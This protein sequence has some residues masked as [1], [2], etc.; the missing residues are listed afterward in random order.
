[1]TLWTAAGL[2][3]LA[4]LVGIGLSV[5]KADGVSSSR[6]TTASQSA[7]AQSAKP[8]AKKKGDQKET[9]VA[10]V[11]LTEIKSGE[12]STY[13]QNTSTL[14]ARN[15]AVLV[16]RRQGQ[17]TAILAEE[18]AW[19]ERGAVLARLDD[20]EAKLAVEKSQLAAEVAKREID[21]AKQ[22]NDQGY[23]SAKE[24]DDLEVKLRNATVELEQARYELSQRVITAPFAGRIVDRMVQLGETV[25][26][27]RD[28]FRIADFQPVLARVYFP[29]RELARVKVGQEATLAL[30]SQPGRTISGRVALVNPVVDRTNGT[31]EVTIEVPNRDGALRPGAVARVRIK[32]GHFAEAILM[33]RRGVL[34]E[35]GEDYVFV[36]RA[37]TVARVPITV[38]TIDG[39][40]MQIL[41]GLRPGD[42]VVTVGQ[43]GLKP[44]AKIKAVTL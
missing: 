20:R 27:G 42:R 35:D 19:A 11:E 44:G 15:V 31:F 3:V 7:P 23:L 21:R 28:C 24:L 39:D 4:A 17:V 8:K 38:G 16:A 40:T 36:A 29:E 30:D 32:T 1:V 14:E 18:G 26:P 43:G 22:L 41:A 25:T 10:P 5:R 12:I 13:L 34:T 9:P 2:L 37:D 33:P 6:K